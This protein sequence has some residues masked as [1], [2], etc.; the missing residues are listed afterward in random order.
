VTSGAG[1]YGFESSPYTKLIVVK[2][3]IE[4]LGKIGISHPYGGV[5]ETATKPGSEWACDEF[6]DPVVARIQ[7]IF[8]HENLPIIPYDFTG[9]PQGGFHI[10][11]R[12]EHRER[13]VKLVFVVNIRIDDPAAAK[14]EYDCHK[15]HIA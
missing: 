7:T 8:P 5:K 1:L 10:S 11:L 9:L 4:R 13:L 2:H 6:F 3:H 12:H 15:T 14:S